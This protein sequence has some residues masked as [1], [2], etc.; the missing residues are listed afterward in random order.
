ML[1]SS[2]IGACEKIPDPSKK[3]RQ[4]QKWN[5]QHPHQHGI[6]SDKEEYKLKGRL[7][8]ESVCFS[9]TNCDQD[10]GQKSKI[11]PK[12]KIPVKNRNFDFKMSVPPN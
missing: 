8:H 3:R 9:C 2:S 4:C 11:F 1:W 12:N 5:S 10:F 7:V 6:A